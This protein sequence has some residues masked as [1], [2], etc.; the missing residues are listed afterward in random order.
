MKH[1]LCK[2]WTTGSNIIDQI[3]RQCALPVVALGHVCMRT[4]AQTLPEDTRARFASVN[5]LPNGYELAPNAGQ[6]L[7]SRLRLGQPSIKLS[8]TK[9]AWIAK[10]CVFFR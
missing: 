5:Q 9:K 6:H 4:I 8:I 7:R 10:L 3:A 2:P 1:S